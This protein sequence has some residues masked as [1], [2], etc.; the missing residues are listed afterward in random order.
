MLFWL[1]E[2]KE[3]EHSTMPPSAHTFAPLLLLLSHVLFSLFLPWNSDDHL[4]L[5]LLAY[6]AAKILF[7]PVTGGGLLFR[8]FGSIE[9]LMNDDGKISERTEMEEEGYEPLRSTYSEFRL[10][11]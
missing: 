4:S 3:G 8:C 6:K 2:K 1:K 11:L 10:L 5:K 7:Q 9:S